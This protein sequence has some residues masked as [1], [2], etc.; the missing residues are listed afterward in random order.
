MWLA[1]SSLV[2]SIGQV[3]QLTAP[4][5]QFPSA[6]K[7]LV[8]FLLWPGDPLSFFGDKSN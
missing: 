6:H 2:I 8:L 5:H 3:L 7:I 4:Q 1:K